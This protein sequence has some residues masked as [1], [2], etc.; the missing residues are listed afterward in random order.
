MRAHFKNCFAPVQ[1][2]RRTHH[3]VVFYLFLYLHYLAGAKRW[4]TSVAAVVSSWTAAL[5]G[6]INSADCI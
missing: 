4:A 6:V 1:V 2:E 3:R 5:H